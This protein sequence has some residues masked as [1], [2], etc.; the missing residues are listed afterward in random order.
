MWPLVSRLI[1]DVVVVKESEAEVALRRLAQE[2]HL[3][4]EGAAAVAVAAA[5]HHRFRNDRVV[6]VLSGGNIDMPT[7]TRIM[8]NGVPPAH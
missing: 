2:S 6:A 7:F 1:D 5:R 4:V 3:I 8:Q